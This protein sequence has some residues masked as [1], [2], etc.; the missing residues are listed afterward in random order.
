MRKKRVLSWL[1]AMALLL[2]TVAPVGY[3]S[4]A[5]IENEDAQHSIRITWDYDWDDNAR[6]ATLPE[7]PRWNDVNVEEGLYFSVPSQ[8][9]AFEVDGVV[10]SADAI[11]LLD[12]EGSVVENAVTRL[13]E[14]VVEISSSSIGSYTLQVDGILIPVQF[15]LPSPGFYSAAQAAE[16]N[17][18]SSFDMAEKETNTFY[19]MHRKDV[20]HEYTVVPYDAS[21]EATE[22]DPYT[23]WQ[24]GYWDEERNEEVRNRVDVSKYVTIGETTEVT[25]TDKNTYVVYPVTLK[26]D[27]V[28]NAER[29]EKYQWQGLQFCIEETWQ[30]D[31]GEKRTDKFTTYLEIA[32]ASNMLMAGRLDMA[33]GEKGEWLGGEI[34][35][36]QNQRYDQSLQFQLGDTSPFAFGT[37]K[38]NDMENVTPVQ[39]K[40]SDFTVYDSQGQEVENAVSLYKVDHNYYSLNFDDYGTY[41]VEYKDA[42]GT[43]Y[44]LPVTVV[45]KEMG[46]YKDQTLVANS[47]LDGGVKYEAGKV[48][49]AYAEGND[50]NTLSVTEESPYGFTYC[51]YGQEEFEPFPDANVK[52]VEN[53]V[54]EEGN[55]ILYKLTL[56]EGITEGCTIKWDTTFSW[57]EE[58]GIRSEPRDAVLSADIY[59][60]DY[61]IYG[62]GEACGYAAWYL[63]EEEY[64][65]GDV[66]WSRECDRYWVHADTV[67]GVLDKLKAAS[68]T[69]TMFYDETTGKKVS[70]KLDNTGYA[71][72]TVNKQVTDTLPEKENVIASDFFKGVLFTSG[73]DPVFADSKGTTPCVLDVRRLTTDDDLAENTASG[74]GVPEEERISGIA[75]YEAAPT[76]REIPAFDYY[77]IF[78]DEAYRVSYNSDDGSYTLGASLE[79]NENQLEV[80]SDDRYSIMLFQNPY[81]FPELNVTAKTDVAFEG[82]YAGKGVF[83]T[84]DNADSTVKV[85]DLSKEQNVVA[86]EYTVA[87]ATEAGTAKTVVTKV[88]DSNILG[89][90]D[91]DISITLI[92]KKEEAPATTTQAPATTTQAPATTTQ[93]PATTTEAPAATTKIVTKGKKASVGNNKYKVTLPGSSKAEV[94]FI[95][96]KKD[97][98]TV[99]IPKTVKIDGVTVKVTSVADN[100][101]TGNKKLKKVTISSNITKVGK[102]A[103][104]NC[105]NLKKIT[106]TSTKIKNIG[107]NAFKGI[108]KNVEIIVP[109]KKY[110]EYKKLLLKAGVPKAVK[111]DK[112]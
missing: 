77:T 20:G 81:T 51:K 23:Y 29:T 11:F 47:L 25:G 104:K 31:T 58:D 80:V 54:N 99:V 93:A 103:F 90:A 30:E 94:A 33:V 42:A 111:I 112:K 62:D 76:G 1:L 97:T 74:E 71:F 48:V 95:G 106:I 57:E 21:G 89:F 110:K 86:A 96:T 41:R 108:P 61:H 83:V 82:K 17:V 73:Q 65:Q 16:G 55:S 9:V 101:F 49:Y 6:K 4:V 87:D 44:T 64:A 18:I 79:L 102:N 24:E 60:S 56:P 5:A 8:R 35:P 12:K 92:K 32:D 69:A 50:W 36:D 52:I 98:A 46:F 63:S 100:A 37:A 53:K 85:L 88:F 59:V 39:P 3:S 13:G 109:K 43:V 14:N 70:K 84:F 40:L 107:K 22:N 75:A 38:K 2:T 45:K 68:E 7:Q 27:T 15:E 105:K 78:N 91:N 66:D 72:V 19:V 10:A 26:N 34:T 28:F 67:Q